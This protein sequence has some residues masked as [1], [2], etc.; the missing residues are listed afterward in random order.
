MELKGQRASKKC[1]QSG[2]LHLD[3]PYYKLKC[4]RGSL[5]EEKLKSVITEVIA[6]EKSLH[7][8][9][10][11][12]VRLKEMRALQNFFIR[13]SNCESW[14]EAQERFP[15]FT[16]EEKLQGF[17]GDVIHGKCK[18]RFLSFMHRVMA[19]EF[20]DR[21][22][23]ASKM[24]EL[25]T[26]DCLAELSPTLTAEIPLFSGSELVFL[27]VPKDWTQEDLKHFLKIIKGIDIRN[28]VRETR[29]VMFP[30]TNPTKIQ[31]KQVNMMASVLDEMQLGWAIAYYQYSSTTPKEQCL[32]TNSTFPFLVTRTS[33]IVKSN[34][35]FSVPEDIAIKERDSGMV[36][37]RQKPVKL[38]EELLEVLKADKS[39]HVIDACSGVASCAVACLSKDIKCVVLEKSAIKA[40]LISQRLKH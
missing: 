19:T 29:Y 12:F 35:H 17:R 38:Y 6:K 26:V 16:T 34:N 31:M 32:L 20:A 2:I 11:E 27:D 18:E 5:T 9:E 37:K 39:Q 10:A 14:K 30:V 24:V 22:N 36:Y 28:N 3:L 40:R 13:H 33:K 25:L 8:M 21:E 7:E 1:L 15:L 4:M 23:P